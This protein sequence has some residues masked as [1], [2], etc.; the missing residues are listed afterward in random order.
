MYGRTNHACMIYVEG[1]EGGYNH[2]GYY[3]VLR[4]LNVCVCILENVLVLCLEISKF[5]SR[6]LLEMLGTAPFYKPF[7]S[8]SDSTVVF[9][10]QCW[11]IIVGKLFMSHKHNI[12]ST[13]YRSL[14]TP[15]FSLNYKQSVS[16]QKD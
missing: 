6:E 4:R 16:P 10:S 15:C 2:D 1:S 5:Q 3:M 11:E 8:W 12:N 7:S 13:G 9:V 14:V